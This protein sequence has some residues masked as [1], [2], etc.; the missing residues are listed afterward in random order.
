MPSVPLSQKPISEVILSR[1]EAQY[2]EPITSYL[3]KVLGC[4]VTFRGMQG[5]YHV[6]FPEGTL[7][8]VYAGQS[9]QW[10]YRTTIHFPT[11]QT[12]TKYVVVSLPH[13]TKS[14]TALAFPIEVLYGPEP[15]RKA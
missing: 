3:E 15:L 14:S 9:T 1:V 10:T 4:R 5:G 2:V 7:E 11:G 6:Q 8:L 13:L 12:L